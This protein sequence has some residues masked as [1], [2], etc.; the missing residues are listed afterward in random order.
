MCRAEFP[1]LHRRRPR[2]DRAD[3][4]NEPPVAFATPRTLR[5]TRR[6]LRAFDL[7]LLPALAALACATA[8]PA[9][10]QIYKCAGRAGIPTYQGTPCPPGQELRNFATDPAE[11]SVLPQPPWPPLGTGAAPGQRVEPPAARP[12]GTARGERSRGGDPT[13]R[14]FLAAG[15]QAGEVL[16]RAGPPDMKAGGHKS[17]RWTYLPHPGDPQTLTTVVIEQGRVVEVE[18]KVVR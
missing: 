16:A 7:V 3:P 6:T 17:T 8:V 11:V 13:Q 4:S 5:C 18:R 12:R 14:R 1:G 2:R 10:A 15:M 9:H